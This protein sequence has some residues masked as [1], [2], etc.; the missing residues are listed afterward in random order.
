[1]LWVRAPRPRA[2]LRCAERLLE[3]RG[4]GVVLVDLDPTAGDGAGE[5]GAPIWARMTRSAQA[6]GTALVL[7]ATQSRVGPFA[8]LTLEARATRVRFAAQPGW[9]DGL[10]AEVAPRRSR[11]G[12]LAG[13]ASVAW[14]AQ[15]G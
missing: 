7:L 5:T 15:G 11:I 2:A 6:G 3:A 14:N 4:F 9:L 13:K 1:V 8:A 12:A 10:D